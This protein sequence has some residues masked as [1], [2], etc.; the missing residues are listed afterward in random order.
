M[1]TIKL[2]MDAFKET[3]IEPKIEN[4]CDVVKLEKDGM[5]NLVI[6]E[7]NSNGTTIKR[8]IKGT[9]DMI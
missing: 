7:T 6:T 1:E 8:F 9:L 3:N 2:N 5:G 4:E